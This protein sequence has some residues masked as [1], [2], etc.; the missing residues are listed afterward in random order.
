VVVVQ[1]KYLFTQRYFAVE[2]FTPPKERAEDVVQKVT[3]RVVR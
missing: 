1:I 3:L 2:I